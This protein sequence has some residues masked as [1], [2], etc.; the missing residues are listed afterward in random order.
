MA[1]SILKSTPAQKKYTTVGCGGCDKYE[2]CLYV[3]NNENEHNLLTV[4]FASQKK[5]LS[6]VQRLVSFT[7]PSIS[8]ILPM[9]ISTFVCH[10]ANFSEK[11][12][13][14]VQFRSTICHTVSLA[15]NSWKLAEFF[16]S[17]QFLLLR[18]EESRNYFSHSGRSGVFWRLPLNHLPPRP[19]DFYAL[20]EKASAN[21]KYLIDYIDH[22][23]M[24]CQYTKE[25]VNNRTA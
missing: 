19:L 18:K 14:R 4:L 6:G 12:E 13:L 9:N 16:W 3:H 10:D 20:Q 8:S 7:L 17:S 24:P 11:K 2:L 1:F 25:S 21:T 22:Q 15:S 5:L 23:K